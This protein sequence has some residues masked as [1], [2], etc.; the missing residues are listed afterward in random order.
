MSELSSRRK[1]TSFSEELSGLFLAD[2]YKLSTRT[3][4]ESTRKTDDVSVAFFL[5][6]SVSKFQANVDCRK[7]YPPAKMNRESRK[8]HDFRNAQ[9][10]TKKK[11]TGMTTGVSSAAKPAGMNTSGGTK[12]AVK[13][14]TLTRAVMMFTAKGSP[15]R[16]KRTSKI[17]V[18]WFLHKNSLFLHI[19]S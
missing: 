14:A 18:F 1:R 16:K 3:L 2:W 10:T 5:D 4:Y 11:L 7:G 17:S 15:D 9:K 13:E 12:Q 19:S 8:R 6:L